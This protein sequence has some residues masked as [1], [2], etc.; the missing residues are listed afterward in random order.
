MR[1][2]AGVALKKATHASGHITPSR[3]MPP[4]TLAARAAPVHAI[5]AARAGWPAPIF[6]RPWPAVRRQGRRS[7]D[8]GRF[9]PHGRAE[10]R[11]RRR[12]ERADEPREQREHQVV[13]KGL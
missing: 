1:W 4:V 12:A 2:M 13:E 10:T 3:P 11:E 8:R 7:A 6:V 9:E 5:R